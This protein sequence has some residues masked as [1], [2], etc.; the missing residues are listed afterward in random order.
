MDGYDVNPDTIFDVQV[1]RL[2]EYKRQ[3]IN[4]F[5]IMAIYF[6]IK[7]GKLPNWTPTTFIFGAKAAPGYARAK[8]I[9]KY[10]TEIAVAT[11]SRVRH[12]VV[13]IAITLPPF[14]LVSLIRRA[15]SPGIS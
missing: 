11:L 15:V 4:A 2:H 8:A 1:K 3:L 7:E 13:P 12:E 6:R 5:S 9:I 14:R 10:I